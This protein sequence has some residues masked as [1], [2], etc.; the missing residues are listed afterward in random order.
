M[1]SMQT[2]FGRA[3]SIGILALM[4]IGAIACSAPLENSDVATGCKPAKAYFCR[5]VNRAPGSKVC[6]DDKTTYS[7][8]DCG[9]AETGDDAPAS[10][11]LGA[12]DPGADPTGGGRKGDPVIV[13]PDQDP[14]Q[15]PDP[16]P[17]DA[18][19]KAAPKCGKL[20]NAA[21]KTSVVS[22]LDDAQ[23]PTG[24][25]IA[26]GTY[27]QTWVVQ[28]R[29]AK[30]SVAEKTFESAQTLEL[31]DDFGRSTVEENA[32]ESRSVGFAYEIV[33][34]TLTITPHCPA[35]PATSFEFSASGTELIVFDGDWVRTFERQE[36]AAE[37]TP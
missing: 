17:A 28:F 13:P 6:N 5:C 22:V 27:V 3:F 31:S 18:P 21:P 1:F 2:C 29:G 9:G 36:L 10:S 34:R 35:G 14:A 16:A 24:G 23:K 37:E 8:C 11:G 12:P 25:A 4:G 19:P 15:D 32:Q 33:G 26:K 7:E 30:G 20:E